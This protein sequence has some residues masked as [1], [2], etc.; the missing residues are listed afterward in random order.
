[1]K[2]CSFFA[3]AFKVCK[4]CYYDPNHFFVKNT[5][6]GISKKNHEKI[7]KK[8]YTNTQNVLIFLATAFLRAFV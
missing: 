3:F 1:L 4:K 8:H 5:N 7:K 2:M 6:M